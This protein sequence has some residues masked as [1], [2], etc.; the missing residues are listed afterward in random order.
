[1]NDITVNIGSKYEVLENVGKRLKKGEVWY[2]WYYGEL[3]LLEVKEDGKAFTDRSLP[4][5]PGI[6]IRAIKAG[7]VKEVAKNE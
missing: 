2:A 1:M 7:K 5:E 4:Y 6:L 3:I